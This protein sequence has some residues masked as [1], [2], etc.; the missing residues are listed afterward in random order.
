[1]ERKR[2]L[3][4][5]PGGFK[6]VFPEI[7]L[8]LLYL[9]WALRRAS[10]DVEILDMRLR[11]FE[12]TTRDGYLFVGISSMTGP[13]IRDG[14]RF[15][16]RVRE[17]DPSIPIVWG[18]IHVTLLPEQALDHSLVDI[19]VRGEGEVTVVELA[20]ALAAGG[21]LSKVKGISYKRDGVI[22]SNPDREFMDMDEIDPDLPYDLLEMDRY[23]FPSFPLHS[24]R[25]CP[26]RC[27]FCYNTAFNKR[28][29]RYKSA[30]RVL[31]EIEYIVTRFG[32]TRF[33]FGHEDEFFI[34]VP[35]VRAICEGMMERGLRVKWASFCRFDSFE[36]VD[37][38]LLG[39]LERT[40]CYS[41]SFG[42]ESGSQRVLDEIIGKDVNINSMIR[43]SGRLSKTNIQ[44][45]VSFMSGLPG[46]SREEMAETFELM[47][48]LME[49]NPKI[50]L[51]GIFLYT[52]YPGTPLFCYVQEKH[53]Y[54]P[55]DTLDAWAEFGIYRNVG[56]TWLAKREAREY[57]ALS[58][59]TRFPFYKE[60][61]RWADLAGAI[62]SSRFMRFPFNVG[63][64]V[65]AN[66]A[67]ARWRA[68]RFEWP[69]EWWL[70][71]KVLERVRGFV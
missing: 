28:R 49:I 42:G 17:F 23:E 9:A 43:A 62:G 6:S 60:R 65:L 21:D 46:V 59:L 36:R 67:I 40:G 22:R 25:G 12:F 70:L 57:K 29:W 26:Y 13:M 16:R 50:Y 27:G 38:E 2:I 4:V 44:Q 64:F 19:V 11:S 48:R 53:G 1:M 58:I 10:Y 37:D 68:R 31:D 33:S 52:P 61:F 39:L 66:V 41:L 45:V 32:Q 15:A 5:Y 34:S 20:E 54:K 56:S 14:L 71:E 24:S 51:N 3:L 63:Y 7:P 69:V 30:R 35:R 8:P 47:D 18:G 55:P